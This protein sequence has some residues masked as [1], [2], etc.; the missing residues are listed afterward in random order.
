MGPSILFDKSAIQSLGRPALQE[1]SRYFYTVVPPVL[2]MET[3]ADLSLKPDD[4]DG[5]KKKVAQIADKVFPINSIANAHCQ[6][7]CVHNLLGDDVGVVRVN[8]EADASGFAGM[9]GTI[10][11]AFQ[12]GLH[13]PR[14]G[15]DF[16]VFTGLADGTH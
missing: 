3:L 8:E 7:M 5:A 16:V 2:L 1:V 6:T 12:H 10:F 15:V 9:Q 14:G 11:R 4:L 13:F